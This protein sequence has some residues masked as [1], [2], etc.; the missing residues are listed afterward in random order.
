[1]IAIR[2]YDQ[3]HLILGVKF[4]GAPSAPVLQACGE[5]NDVI[6]IDY[7]T[8]TYAP[9]PSTDYISQ[10]YQY[11]QK[12]IIIAEFAYRGNVISSLFSGVLI[13][14]YLSDHYWQDSGIPNR[15][16]AGLLVPT[17]TARA[18]GYHNYT[19]ILAASP[20][21]IGF[22]WF[23]WFDEPYEGRS[24]DGEDS[25]YGVVNVVGMCSLWI[26][27]SSLYYHQTKLG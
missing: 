20:Y 19:T 8:S 7:Y 17:Q 14:D 5:Y 16:G 21:V 22:H 26:C 11:A 9:L 1:M 3:N 10:I 13:G 15:Q 25:N 18:Q 27:Y 6:S 2:T 4:A 12:P 24:L 23:M